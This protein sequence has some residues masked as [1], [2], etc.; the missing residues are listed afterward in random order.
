M[1][2]LDRVVEPYLSDATASPAGLIV[3]SFAE[4]DRE[5]DCFNSSLFMAGEIQRYSKLLP[6][7]PVR[8]TCQQNSDRVM[9]VVY[10][11]REITE[12]GCWYWHYQV[13]ESR[14]NDLLHV[15]YCAH[16][17]IEYVN[18]DGRHANLFDIDAINRYV[19]SFRDTYIW[20]E[21]PG[22]KV[23]LRLWSL[24]MGLYVARSLND[25]EVAHSII[26][27]SRRYRGAEPGIYFYSPTILESYIRHTAHFLFGLSEYLY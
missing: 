15:G 22:S 19:Y 20:Y 7:G 26:L 14:L 16:G 6:D 23:E 13:A 10:D 4:A 3:Y 11:Y 8:D 18:S 5:Y 2:V 25:S 24:G 27:F 1:P 21:L 12:G 17:V 9:Q